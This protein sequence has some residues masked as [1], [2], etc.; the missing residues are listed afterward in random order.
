MT[1]QNFIDI[2]DRLFSWPVIALALFLIFKKPV[3]KIL[4]ELVVFIKT[5]GLTVKSPGGTEL[6]MLPL[7]AEAETKALEEFDGGAFVLSIE[8]QDQLLEEIEEIKW[9]MIKAKDEKGALESQIKDLVTEKEKEIFYWRVQYLNL[10][11]VPTTKRVLEWFTFLPPDGTTVEIYNNIWKTTIPDP[12]GRNLIL[13]V[14]R[15][16]ELLAGDEGGLKI[17]PFGEFFIKFTKGLSTIP[18]PPSPGPTPPPLRS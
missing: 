8:E 12:D 2:I 18:A 16:N 14:L 17:T 6:S 9:K 3:I 11:L 1:W 7:Q 13:R 5:R 10:F 15:E 4:E